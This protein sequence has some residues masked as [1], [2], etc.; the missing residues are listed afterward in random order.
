R[1]QNAPEQRQ[2]QMES[3]GVPQ[4]PLARLTRERQ[5]LPDTPAVDRR[6]DLR[7]GLRRHRDHG[8]RFRA[9]SDRRS[10]SIATS[11]SFSPSSANASRRGGRAP[12]VNTMPV[13]RLAAY[14]E[15]YSSQVATT[16]SNASLTLSTS[17]LE[18]RATLVRAFARRLD[19]RG[20]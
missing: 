1:R 12:R 10:S 20:G 11:G 9:R 3:G 5:F 17:S 16:P 15:R 18:S 6:H 7:Q 8:R 13:H 14:D 2:V 19:R 4:S